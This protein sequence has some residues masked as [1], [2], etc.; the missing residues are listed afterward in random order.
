MPN[1]RFSIN[2]FDVIRD[3]QD[4]IMQ[5][6]GHILDLGVYRSVSTKALARIFPS[7]IIHGFDSFEG[8][9]EDWGHQ[10]KGA[11]G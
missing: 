10:G 8:L 11:F 7:K 4:E 1:A 6:D 5:L 2:Q 3:K 9:P